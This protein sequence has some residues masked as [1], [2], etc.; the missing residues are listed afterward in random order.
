MKINCEDR[1]NENEHVKEYSMCYHRNKPNL[2][3]YCGVDWVFHHWPS[4]NILSYEDT[5]DEIIMAST[6][7]PIINKVGWYGNLYSPKP[8]VI[9]YK[10]RPLLKKIGDMYPH[11]F[12]IIHILPNNGVIDG[13]IK[14]YCSLVDLLQYRYLIDIGGNG[15]SGRLKFLLFSKR[16]LLLVDR[17]YIEYFHNDLQPYVHYIPVNM[18]L[19]NL[20]EQ[21]GWMQ[22]NDAQCIE[23]ANN[24]FQYAITHFTEEKLC[25]RIAYVYNHLRSDQP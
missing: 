13:S 24:A 4:A 10:T 6:S 1:G 5:V 23:I 16:P 21:I 19:S 20:M 22:N 15:Y 25:E 12:D 11:I 3:K 17:N 18:D 14:Q 2:E 8:D 7:Q 9:E